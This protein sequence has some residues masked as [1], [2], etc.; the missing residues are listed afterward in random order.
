M[1]MVEVVDVEREDNVKKLI[2]MK[3]MMQSCLFKDLIQ[4]SVMSLQP[5]G[6]MKKMAAFKC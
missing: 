2:R 4:R 1:L 6:Q 3:D 5:C